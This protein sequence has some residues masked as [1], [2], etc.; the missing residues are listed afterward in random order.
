MGRKSEINLDGAEIS[1]IK[2]IGLAGGG[3][4]GKT[5]QDRLGDFVLAELVD[6]VRGLIAQGYVEADKGAFHRQEDFEKTWFHVNS[7]YA[8]DLKEALNPREEPK[9]SKRVRRE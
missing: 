3:V 2:A 1:V 7:G 9:R 8:H 5:M 4:D 6:T